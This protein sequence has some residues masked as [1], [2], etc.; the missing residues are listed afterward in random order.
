MVSTHGAVA[1]PNL[2]RYRVRKL[3][4]LHLVE[5]RSLR[6]AAARVALTVEERNQLID[7][8]GPD[9]RVEVIPNV[10]DPALVGA[11]PWEPPP[12]LS[13]VVTLA[14]WDVRHKGLDRL[15]A[16]AERLPDQRFVVHGAPCGNEPERLE[17]LL[18]EA[19]TNL[20]LAAAVDADARREVL[21]HAAAFALL[22]RWEGLSM[23]LLEA[24]ALGVP[25]LVSPEVARTLGPMPPVVALPSDEPEAAA[26]EV[27][28]LLRDGPRCAAIGRAGR[29]WA[30]GHAGAEQVARA[31]ER[32]YRQ[33][34]DEA[35][36]LARRGP[37]PS[38]A[39]QGA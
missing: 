30:I 2:R 14:R 35:G 15:A 32:L 7:R 27:R 5:R 20:E 13:P 9:P 34:I 8:F 33:V 24:M 11:T 1:P 16:L 36:A 38:P 26:R 4:Y 39:A 28:A 29:R 3:A 10:A 6:R 12:G 21:R 18:E 37:H 25:C 22:S 19:P 31:S 17:A 23:A